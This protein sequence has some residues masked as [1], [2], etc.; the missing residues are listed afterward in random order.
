MKL[1]KNIYL[2]NKRCFASAE[3]ILLAQRLNERSL[4]RLSGKDANLYLQ[5]LITNDMKHL[6]SGASSMY[7]MFLNSK[8]RVL[9]DSIIYNTNIENTFYVECD[10]N[11]SLYLKDHLMHF[12]VRRKVNIDL[13][14]DEFS[15]WALAFKDYIIN[16]KDVYNY[17]PVL[18]ELK[19]NLPQ[20]IITNDPRLPSMGLRVLTQKDYNLVS[21]IK[22]VADV[23]VQGENFYK[24]LR[25]NLGI[26]EGL[27]E[28]PLEKCFP[29]EINGDY[30]HGIS[31]HKGCYVGQELTARTYHTGVIRKRIMPLKFNEEVSITQ[32]GIPIF[33]VS[34]LTKAIGKVFGVEQTSGLGLL[35]IEEALKA[36]ELITFK[37]KC[38]THRPFWWPNEAPKMRMNT[39]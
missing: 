25:Y 32:P 2:L 26:G 20:L 22:K 19:K 1:P 24:F 21:E 39:G 9:Y 35:R 34:Q 18:N 12:K 37:K 27:N 5:G 11:A 31:F 15:V 8:G 10:S 16:P 13:L 17:K 14:S 4:L 3:K 23:N 7:T 38:Y 28:L 30:L 36:D 29:M 6:E 33:S